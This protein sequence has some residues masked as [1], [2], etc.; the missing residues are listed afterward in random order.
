MA[1]WSSDHH[2]YT[3]AFPSVHIWLLQ[4]RKRLIVKPRIR[5]HSVLMKPWE[6]SKS[7]I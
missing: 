5:I 4:S 3:A 1:K 7:L 2:F 6:Y